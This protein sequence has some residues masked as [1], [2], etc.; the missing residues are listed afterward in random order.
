MII[1]AIVLSASFL[2]PAGLAAQE[3]N[4][5][6]SIVRACFDAASEWHVNSECIGDA[7]NLCQEAPQGSTTL[8][9]ATCISA[10]T[11]VWDGILNAEYQARQAE[12]AAYEPIGS[13]AT[14][15]ELTTGLRDAQRAWMAFRDADCNLRYTL[16]QDGSIRTIVATSCHLTKTAQRAIELRDIGGL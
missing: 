9:I 2:T 12:F 4:V 7:A 11:Q 1:R 13:G 14:A 6:A 15:E 3:L 8:G 10:E 16:F 5:D